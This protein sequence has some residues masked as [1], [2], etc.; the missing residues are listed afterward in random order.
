MSEE[1]KQVILD[2][3][4][5]LRRKIAKGEEERGV[6]GPQPPA[7]NMR[8][9]RWNDELASIAQRWTDQCVWGHD[10]DRRKLDGTWAGQN[11]FAAGGWTEETREEVT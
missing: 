8:E 11:G 3:H 2:K 1:A 4:N 6:G 10:K 9:L 7:S 5:E